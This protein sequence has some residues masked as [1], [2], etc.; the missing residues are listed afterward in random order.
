VDRKVDKV[1]R[2]SQKKSLK[3]LIKFQAIY[4]KMIKYLRFKKLREIVQ[5]MIASVLKTYSQTGNIQTIQI[6]L[7]LCMT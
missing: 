4:Q 5:V 1:M 7:D 3:A 6:S 2:F